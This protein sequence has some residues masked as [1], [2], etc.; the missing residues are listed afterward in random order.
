MVA[1]NTKKTPRESASVQPATK[2]A[3]PKKP[4]TTNQLTIKPALHDKEPS[5]RKL[6]QKGEEGKAG[7][8]NL[9]D[10]DDEDQQESIPHEE[11]LPQGFMENMKAHNMA[12][13]VLNDKPEV[14]AGSM[15]SENLDDT[16]KSKAR[17]ESDS[18]IPDPSHQTVTSTPPVIA[19]FTAV[20]SSKPSLL[21]HLPIL[22][23]SILKATTITTSLLEITPFNRLQLRGS[24]ERHTAVNEK[25]SVLPGQILSRIQESE[26]LRWRL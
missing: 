13:C 14:I 26:R 11:A 7:L 18:T 6:P 4:T 2:R 24:L 8:S 1:A 15:S 19:P 21:V 17:E 25:Y 22:H 12:N 16:E 23:Q 10:E 5:K 9:V 20:T 3:T